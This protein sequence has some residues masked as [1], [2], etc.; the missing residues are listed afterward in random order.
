MDAFTLSDTYLLRGA[1][2]GDI[3]SVQNIS[4]LHE[5]EGGQSIVS[6]KDKSQ[7]IMVITVGRARVE[8]R[9]GELLD[10][11]RKGDIIGEIAFLDGR[12]RTANVIAIGL[13]KVLVIPADRLRDLMKKNPALEII[14]LRNIALSLC[15]R[16]RDANQQVETCQAP[17]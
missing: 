1:A 12:G 17:R 2:M 16:L 8:T 9:D 15:Q 14:L 5:F 4:E 13:A 10:E 6:D 7:D 11:L 3:D